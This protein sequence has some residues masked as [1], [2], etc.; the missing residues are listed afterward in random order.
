MLEENT[1]LIQEFDMKMG[2]YSDSTGPLIE[3]CEI[4]YTFSDPSLTPA[5]KAVIRNSYVFFLSLKSINGSTEIW[6]TDCS[7]FEDYN[8]LNPGCDIYGCYIETSGCPSGG[9]GSTPPPPDEPQ[10]PFEN[11][12]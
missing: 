6:Y 1:E 8:D 12:Q 5:E 4:E 11:Q 3:G 7:D 9:C 2:N 10:D